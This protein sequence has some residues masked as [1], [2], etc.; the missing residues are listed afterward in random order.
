LGLKKLGEGIPFIE[1]Y[2][3][4]HALSG[5]LHSDLIGEVAHA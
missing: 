5:T 3:E 4:W 1:A 2:Y